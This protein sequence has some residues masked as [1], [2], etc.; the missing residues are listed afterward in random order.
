MLQGHG[1]K[2]DAVYPIRKENRTMAQAT[3]KPARKT[4]ANTLVRGP[5]GSL[6]MISHRDL[7]PFKVHEEKAKKLDQLLKSAKKSPVRAKLS[8]AIVRR[9]QLVDACV[10]TGAAPDIHINT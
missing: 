7:A 5:D 1:K 4:E 6:Y 3:R 10:M 8:A 9:I 2:F